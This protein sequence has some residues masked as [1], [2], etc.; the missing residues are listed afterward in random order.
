MSH[1]ARQA[2]HKVVRFTMVPLGGIADLGASTKRP[3]TR[4]DMAG[5][6]ARNGDDMGNSQVIDR[7]TVRN[8]AQQIHGSDTTSR[9]HLHRLLP[10]D[11]RNQS[12][13]PNQAGNTGCPTRRS[14]SD[15]GRTVCQ[16]DR[17][18]AAKR[19]VR[20]DL[21]RVGP[22]TVRIR[23]H[24]SLE[25]P[26]ASLTAKRHVRVLKTSAWSSTGAAEG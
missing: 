23:S 4:S 3:F 17:K 13:G 19:H 15:S 12:R 11:L 2:R 26:P 18:C 1:R 8:H 7:G 9:G 21:R 25:T 6:I 20:D 14:R 24:D 16:S 10:G 5:G 22:L